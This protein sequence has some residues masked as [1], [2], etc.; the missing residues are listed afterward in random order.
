M[1][2]ARPDGLLAGTAWN[3]I[4]QALPLLAAVASIPFLVR[5]MGLER[6]GF[7]ALAWVLIGYAS[8]LDLGLA[9]ALVRSV[10]E[11]LAAGDG[12]GAAARAR[13]GLSLLLV[14][15]LLVGTALALAAPALAQGLLKVPP[16]LQPEAE[17]ALLALAASMPF[18]MLTAGYSGVLQAH[19]AFRELNLVRLVF[20]LLS[21]GVPLALAAA[22]QVGLPVVVGSI[23][24]L[25]VVATLAFAR[26]CRRHHGFAWR[27][28]WPARPLVAEL[29][30]L[31]GWIGVSNLVG[32]LLTYLDR[33]LIATLVP[34]RAVGLYAA[35]YDLVSRA[36][37]VPY[38]VAS[39]FF[40]K[41][42]GLLP[43]QPEAARALADSCRWLYLT[44]FPLLLAMM[45]LAHP[46]LRLLLGED[47]STEAAWVLQ[48][49]VLGVFAN[50][51]AQGP[52]LL[53]QGAGRP[54]D[55]ALLHLAEL[56]PFLLLLAW[57]TQRHGIVGTAAAAA[58]RFAVDALAVALIAQRGLRL[59]P[60]PWRRL[61]V[62]A[63]WTLLLFGAAAACRSLPQALALLLPGLAA[64]AW[65]AWRQLLMPH[66][67]ARL[68]ALAAARRRT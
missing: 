26:T 19:Q 41:V 62:S 52:A 16:A 3:L 47:G 24:L 8:L 51:L 42:A 66:E 44:M 59:P 54:R 1:K 45:A 65:W 10:A 29:V 12:D 9:R 23:V 7:L 46:G 55:M 32:P 63:A 15:G 36:M 28:A 64:W 35:P 20:S 37:V 31:G 14:L 22:G 34:L 50:T 43:G 48:L 13:V 17:P 39:T 60:W 6:F 67:R 5:W 56:L 38:A 40:P 30:G 58:L 21:Y 25:R 4:G 2:P 33:L 49:L 53:V 11:R 18:V 68:R 27:P 61:L 57:L